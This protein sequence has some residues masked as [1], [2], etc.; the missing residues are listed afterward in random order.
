M[1]VNLTLRESSENAFGFTV[2][3]E[4]A[5]V[6]NNTTLLNYYDVPSIGVNVSQEYRE[7]NENVVNVL[8]VTVVSSDIERIESVI[9]K[10]KKTSDTEFKSV[11][12][13]ILINEGSDAGR[14]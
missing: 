6:S 14:F 1:R 11:G 4:K 2:A 3:D 13:A 12:Q 9:L 7:V 5:I 10:Y 8:V